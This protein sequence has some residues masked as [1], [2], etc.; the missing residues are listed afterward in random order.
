MRASWIY[1]HKELDWWCRLSDYLGVVLKEHV[2]LRPDYK[3][4]ACICF[5]EG[6]DGLDELFRNSLAQGFLGLRQ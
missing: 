2:L 5:T 4:R 1:L 6:F 3:T